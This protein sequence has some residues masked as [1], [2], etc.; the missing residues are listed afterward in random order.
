MLFSI[1]IFDYYLNYFPL[2]INQ[3]KKIRN[4]YD[5]DWGISVAVICPPRY[6]VANEK[7]SKDL[8]VPAG[9]LFTFQIDLGYNFHW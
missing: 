8:I 9:S 3:F 4:N 5:A 7:F 2:S 1:N 6:T